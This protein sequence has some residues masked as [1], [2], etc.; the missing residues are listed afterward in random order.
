MGPYFPAEASSSKNMKVWLPTLRSQQLLTMSPSLS[1]LWTP[2]TCYTVNWSRSCSLRKPPVARRHLRKFWDSGG[3]GEFIQRKLEG[4][5]GSSGIATPI[6]PTAYL[7]FLPTIWAF[8][9]KSAPSDS[10]SNPILMAALNHAIKTS[11]KSASKRLTIEFVS[12]LAL[13]R[14]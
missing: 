2:T 11:S 5:L 9:V 1:N 14:V 7:D 12:R 8:I 4:Q 6:G 3:V 10:G 13:V